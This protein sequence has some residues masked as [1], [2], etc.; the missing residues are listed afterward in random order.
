MAGSGSKWASQLALSL[1]GQIAGTRKRL[2]SQHTCRMGKVTVPALSCSTPKCQVRRE[3]NSML[4][5]APWMP[6][7][8]FL[9]PT[10]HRPQSFPTRVLAQKAGIFRGLIY[11][12]GIGRCNG[13]RGFVQIV[14]RDAKRRLF[15]MFSWLHLLMSIPA[16]C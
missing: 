9:P 7:L 1:A 11:K 8:L 13:F 4:P 3:T 5:S 6:A 12:V 14:K 10:A 15:F 2:G 16:S